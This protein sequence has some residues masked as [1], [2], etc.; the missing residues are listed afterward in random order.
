M[1][2][3]MPNPMQQYALSVKNLTKRFGDLAAVNDI[4]LKIP[5][6]ITYGI[7]GPN[8]AGK[9]TTIKMIAGLLRR[10]LQRVTGRQLV[11][12]HRNWLYGKD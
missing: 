10:M 7:L 2:F 11:F 8:G 12:V 5:T 1:R 4:S 6:G 9:S 3:Q